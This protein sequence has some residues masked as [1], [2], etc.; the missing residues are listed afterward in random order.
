MMMQAHSAL[1]ALEAL[2]LPSNPETLKVL[3]GIPN[4]RA[5]LQQYLDSERANDT[6]E[7]VGTALINRLTRFE[8]ATKAAATEPALDRSAAAALEADGMEMLVPEVPRDSMHTSMP[9]LRC[10]T[11][12][13]ASAAHSASEALQQC[14]FPSEGNTHLQNLIRILKPVAL[15]GCTLVIAWRLRIVLPHVVGALSRR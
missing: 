2:T 11:S 14:T 6:A 10:R 12:S 7:A 8:E 13:S 4:M 9:Q 3:L 15:G 1:M 5:T